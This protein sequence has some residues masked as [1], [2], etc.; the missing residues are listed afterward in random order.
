MA[1]CNDHHVTGT[2]AVLLPGTMVFADLSTV[3]EL[4]PPWCMNMTNL[5]DDRIDP[6]AH[7]F[8]ALAAGAPSGMR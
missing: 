5:L 1:V 4:S 8:G 7:F 6:A 3:R 2:F